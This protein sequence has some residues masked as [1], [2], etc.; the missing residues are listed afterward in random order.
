MKR[1]ESMCS[2]FLPIK[3]FHKIAGKQNFYRNILILSVSNLKSL[4]IKEKPIIAVISSLKSV[5]TL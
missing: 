2:R 3:N 5:N 4:I 1:N